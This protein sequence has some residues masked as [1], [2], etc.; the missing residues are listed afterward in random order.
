MPLFPH[1]EPF[2]IA[3]REFSALEILEA[4]SE[5]VRPERQEKLR[6]VVEGRTYTIIPVLE[7]LYDRGN[8]SAVMRSGEALGYQMM[9]IIESSKKFKKANR[10]TQGAD[11]WLDI[12]RWDTTSDC[13]AHLKDNGYRIIATHVEDAKPIDEVSFTEPAALVLG[14]EHEGV[15]SELLDAADERV[16]I[17]MS[18]FSRSFNISVAAALSLYHIAHERAATETGHGD[19]SKTEKDC[20]LASYYLRSIEA[21]DKILARL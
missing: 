19:L 14:N 13:V 11:K 15:S 20:L 1:T 2:K 5:Y 3:D 4:L 16:V 8:V 21:S 10:V 17:P 12:V 18:G 6:R 9:H 7:G